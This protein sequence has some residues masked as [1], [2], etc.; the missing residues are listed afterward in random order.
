MEEEID[1]PLHYSKPSPR[2]LIRTS[3]H[4][5]PSPRQR[6]RFR[7]FHDRHDLPKFAHDA[8]DRIQT[9]DR[10]VLHER[11]LDRGIELLRLLGPVVLLRNVLDLIC[12]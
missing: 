11:K 12:R 9:S 2:Q 5:R 8:L 4:S 1:S 10:L 6:L 7:R 3:T